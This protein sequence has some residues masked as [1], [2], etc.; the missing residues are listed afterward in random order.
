MGIC[1]V[2]PRCDHESLLGPPGKETPMVHIQAPEPGNL[3]D[4][5]WLLVAGTAALLLIGAALGIVLAFLT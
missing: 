4:V 2:G 3:R 1:F 5:L